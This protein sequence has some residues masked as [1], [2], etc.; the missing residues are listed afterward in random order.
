MGHE[1]DFPS[2]NLLAYFV[3]CC[4]IL[5]VS[6]VRWQWS[7]IVQHSSF[8]RSLYD[9]LGEVS[10]ASLLCRAFFPVWVAEW[11][12]FC[13]CFTGR[14]LYFTIPNQFKSAFRPHLQ[15]PPSHSGPG[16]ARSRCGAGGVPDRE[17]QVRLRLASLSRRSRTQRRT[18][19]LGMFG[20]K[21]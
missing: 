7:P 3:G 13:L 10:M 9:G 19:G 5:V 8:Q 2:S 1:R 4:Q 21:I 16:L 20:G 12:R 14:N 6:G 18:Q 17:R 15:L 11:Q